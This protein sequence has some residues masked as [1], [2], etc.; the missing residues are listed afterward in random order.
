ML[1]LLICDDAPDAREGLRASLAAQPGIEVVAEA[2]NGEEAISLAVAHRP[3]VVLMDVQMPVLDGVA[4][5]RRIREVL[6]QTRIVAYAGS[7][8]AGDVMAMMEAGADAYCLK[9]APL[10]ELER[11]VAGA[12]DPLVRLAHAI[13]RSVNGGGTAELVA[14]E[15]A[16]LT[17]AAFAATYLASADTSLSLAALSGP[18]A[19]E[20][21]HSA[22]GV[23]QRA[24]S[25]LAL[26]QADTH[27]LGELYRLGAACGEAIAAPLVVDGQVAGRAPRRPARERAVDRRSRSSCPRSPISRPPRWRTSAESR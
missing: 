21:L 15:L 17:G 1:R 25:E 6:P 3:D 11:A 13:A 4:A 9:G 5:T 18:G 26:A 23:V 20:S 24:F 16:E 8:D 12:S 10:W 22:P 27:E 2:E 7:D 19:P 14:R